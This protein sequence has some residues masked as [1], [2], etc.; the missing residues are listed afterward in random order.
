MTISGFAAAG[1]EINRPPDRAA[2][3]TPEW[4]EGGDKPPTGQGRRQQHLSGG[5]VSGDGRPYTKTWCNASVSS[6]ICSLSHDDFIY[7]LVS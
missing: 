5:A 7:C 4:G 2:P 3:A 6:F 1:L